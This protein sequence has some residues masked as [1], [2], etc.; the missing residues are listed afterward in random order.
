M[1]KYSLLDEGV[2]FFLRVCQE[3]TSHTRLGDNGP[4]QQFICQ[5]V[6]VIRRVFART[7]NEKGNNDFARD[8]I[9]KMSARD[10]GTITVFMDSFTGYSTS[11]STCFLCLGLHIVRVNVRIEL[12]KPCSTSIV[13]QCYIQYGIRNNCSDICREHL[14]CNYAHN[15]NVSI[16][17][18][19]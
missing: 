19:R 14:N 15:S 5:P 4:V 1:N 8:Q 17:F 18:H 10:E 2:Q 16:C 6:V 11:R 9:N 13:A 3:Q 7:H 12:T